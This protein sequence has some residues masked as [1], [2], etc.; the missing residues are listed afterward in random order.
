MIVPDLD[1]R[2]KESSDLMLRHPD[3][4]PVICEKSMKSKLP[5]LEKN[6]FLLPK[7]LQSYYFTHIIRTKVRLQ[8]DQS[9]FL[10]VNGELPIKQN[11][12]IKEVYDRYKD[13]DGYLY[14][15]YTEETTLGGWGLF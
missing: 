13:E 15:T 7:N 9:F 1:E 11:S 2:R 8:S 4:I 3:K 12:T 5:K 6:R 14:I 10:F